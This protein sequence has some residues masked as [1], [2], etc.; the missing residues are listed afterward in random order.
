MI[1]FVILAISLSDKIFINM[2]PHFQFSTAATLSSGVSPSAAVLVLSA[3]LEDGF[4]AIAK[5]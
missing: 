1:S 2:E 3:R 4:V 5:R